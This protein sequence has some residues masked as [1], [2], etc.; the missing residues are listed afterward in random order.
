[1]TKSN[2]PRS[3]ASTSSKRG[4]VSSSAGFSGR[5][6][7]ASSDSRSMPLSTTAAAS[8]GLADDDRAEPDLRPHA[9]QGVD[10]GPPHVAVHEDDALAGLGDG[11]GQVGGDRRSCR[12][13]CSGW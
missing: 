2:C 7:H 12:R 6:P 3:S 5:G 1:M 10:A 13:P 11:D 9:E 8:G 4:W